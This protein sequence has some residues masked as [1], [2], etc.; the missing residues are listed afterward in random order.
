MHPFKRYATLSLSRGGSRL[1]LA[2]FLLPFQAGRGG[3]DAA[4]SIETLKKMK[5]NLLFVIG[6]D[7]TQAA[8]HMLF[9]AAKAAKLEVSIVGVPKS[10]DNDVLFFDR[11]FG[12]QTAV[13]SAASIIKNGM[14]AEGGVEP[15]HA[16]CCLRHARESPC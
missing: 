12:F 7:G 16:C 14:R 5:I 8:A 13:A 11:T 2:R 9:E 6:G 10:I 3:F 15:Q 4:K 1:R